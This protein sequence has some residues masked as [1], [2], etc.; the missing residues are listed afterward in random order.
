MT[1]KRVN[2][3]KSLEEVL[4]RL[5]WIRSYE[6]ALVDGPANGMAFVE[7]VKQASADGNV[8]AGASPDQMIRLGQGL[9]ALGRGMKDL[10]PAAGMQSAAQGVDS[11]LKAAF[12]AVSEEIDA[13]LA[14]DKQAAIAPEFGKI[15]QVLAGIKT[16]ALM[17]QGIS[18][19]ACASIIRRCDEAACV[20]GIDGV[21]AGAGAKDEDKGCDEEQGHKAEG[22]VP[23]EGVRNNAKRGLELR[24]KHGRG[25]TE[26]GVARARDLSNGKAVSDETIGR[27]VNFFGRH[28]KNKAGGEDDAGYIAWMLWGGDAGKRWAESIYKQIKGDKSMG[29]GTIKIVAIGD[30]A[31]LAGKLL[32]GDKEIG[33]I[34]GVKEYAI[35]DVEPGQYKLT[36]QPAQGEALVSDVKVEA[37]Q[38]SIIEVKA[39]QAAAPVIEG[40]ALK[41][42]LDY[43]KTQETLLAG[44]KA[45]LD[46]GLKGLSE[47]LGQV[48]ADVKGV[49]AAQDAARDEAKETAKQIAAAGVKSA[50]VMQQVPGTIP[51]VAGAKQTEQQRQAEIAQRTAASSFDGDLAASPRLKEIKAQGGGDIGGLY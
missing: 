34:S 42:G 9:L 30:K 32:L 44:I 23:P 40:N 15:E 51:V 35:A 36:L 39:A 38:E 33:E 19:Q 11:A 25:G 5:F 2:F 26:T 41:Q 12:E 31:E 6:V 47:R 27:M 21:K 3:V 45:M 13:L 29:K 18:P 37:G 49:K 22:Y 4:R 46:E 1:V 48:E 24:R 16:E 28:E 17:L 50:Q 8:L 20:L 43:A 10:G 14:G 7:A